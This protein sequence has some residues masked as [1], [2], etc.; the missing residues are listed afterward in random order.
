ML[1]NAIKSCLYLGFILFFSAQA[2]G[3]LPPDKSPFP[4]VQSPFSHVTQ[5]NTSRQEF[6]TPFT[7]LEI[8]GG[9]LTKQW[10]VDV[11]THE[12]QS[13][14]IISGDPRDLKHISIES[15]QDTLYIRTTLDYPQCGPIHIEIHTQYLNTLKLN[16]YHGRFQ[17]LNLDT[18]YF[19]ADLDHQGS[20]V[21]QGKIDLRHL[22]VR[23]SGTTSIHEVNSQSV[24]IDLDDDAVVDMT[25]M[26]NLKSVR[27]N[28]KGK[29][30][31]YW[32]NSELLK[33]RL[34]DQSVVEL[35]GVTDML[36]AELRDQAYF[37][38]R[39]LRAKRGYVKTWD[40]S[41]ADIQ[42]LKAQAVLAQDESTINYFGNPHYRN[43]F[44]GYD[45]AVLDYNDH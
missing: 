44:M 6:V 21:L 38:G 13:Y 40:H 39:Y 12:K 37:N 35:A 32:V 10:D 14:I 30:R 7:R 33:L 2:A 17:A 28:G 27:V 1:K 43:N 11:K 25:G 41:V 29:L 23:G 26:A 36:Y 22:K 24:T 42:L 16:G 34:F 9:P 4:T 3:Y 18:H 20:V 15:Q 8:D 45:G 31:F 19:N 5:T